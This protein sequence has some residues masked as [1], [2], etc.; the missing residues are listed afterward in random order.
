VI[1]SDYEQN[2]DLNMDF[3][4]RIFLFKQTSYRAIKTRPSSMKVEG[5][6]IHSTIFYFYRH[7]FNNFSE[8]IF[9]KTLHFSRHFSWL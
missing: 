5:Q 3:P 8:N 7:S 6:D 2:S 4:A 1:C 9:S